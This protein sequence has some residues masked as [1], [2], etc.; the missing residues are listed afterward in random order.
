MR[1]VSMRATSQPVE[2]GSFVGATLE[3]GRNLVTAAVMAAAS[4]RVMSSD[5][6]I[7]LKQFLSL[8]LAPFVQV[9]IAI[10]LLSISML[11]LLL[12]GKHYFGYFKVDFRRKRGFLKYLA[13]APLMIFVGLVMI[14]ITFGAVV[15]AGAGKG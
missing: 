12:S 2:R 14:A 9:S 10:S 1:K 3:L 15:I 8:T 4:A 5:I 11:W 7:L 13:I 6:S